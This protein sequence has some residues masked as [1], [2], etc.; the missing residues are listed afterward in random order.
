MESTVIDIDDFTTAKHK[1]IACC[2]CGMYQYFSCSYIS[3]HYSLNMEDKN[4]FTYTCINCHE[5]LALQRQIDDLRD[6]N[7]KL[8]DR[9]SSLIHLRDVENSFD[10]TLDS[11]SFVTNQFANFSITSNIPYPEYHVTVPQD[12]TNSTDN[13]NVTSVWDCESDAGILQSIGEN[14]QVIQNN[15]P[16][17]NDTGTVTQDADISQMSR[18]NSVTGSNNHSTETRCAQEDVI[19]NGKNKKVSFIK[20]ADAH[21][22]IETIVIGDRNLVNVQL[23]EL[24]QNNIRSTTTVKIVHPNAKVKNTIGTIDSLKRKT[25]RNIKTV[26]AHVGVND[27][28]DK[29]NTRLY[30]E[31]NNL[32]QLCTEY[33]MKLIISG[34]I[35]TP[36]MST[37]IFSRLYALNNWLIS[38]TSENDIAFIDSFD[39]F[40][41]K[42][43]LFN[44]TGYDLNMLGAMTLS[45]HLRSQIKQLL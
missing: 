2:S 14:D 9:V 26:V 11:M 27:L 31:Y 40:W 4:F 18:V 24:T 6:L 33:N 29:C 16:T 7:N 25:Y 5:K 19:D 15:I 12:A 17:D 3:S 38:W 39:T 23:P 35:I 10:K 37:E 13:T 8:Q 32:L 28:K 21:D 42:K 22:K 45:N 1:L 34:P 30:D 43:H 41:L 36:S 44:V 20:H